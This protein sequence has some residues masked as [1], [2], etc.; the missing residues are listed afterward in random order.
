MAPRTRSH[1]SLTRTQCLVTGG[2]GFL[3]QHLVRQLVD[4]GKYDVRVFDI[5]DAD[6]PGAEVVTGDLR[7]QAQVDAAVAGCEVVFH[8][9][10]AAPTGENALNVKLMHSVNVLG[11]QHIIAACQKVGTGL[12]RLR[13][14]LRAASAA[15]A[16]GRWV[17]PPK[18]LLRRR[19]L[20]LSPCRPA[21]S[22]SSTPAPPRWCLRARTATTWTRRTPTP[23]SPSTTTP[24]PRS[25]V[26]SRASGACA[27]GP[28]A[29]SRT[30][31]ARP[32]ACPPAAAA[33]VSRR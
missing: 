24:R 33:A 16:G 31:G 7:D 28:A 25:R 5:R 10:T 13:G 3:G 1:G 32:P 22:A 14:A 29:G 9:A 30:P 4:S 19:L 11:T 15:P 6:V 21:S 20:P 8:C 2:L 18:R 12:P 23:P 17:L 27:P 26:G